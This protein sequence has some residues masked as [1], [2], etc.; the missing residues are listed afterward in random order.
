MDSIG[1]QRP[2]PRTLTGIGKAG[3][4]V[5]MRDTVALSRD[6]TELTIEFSILADA[7]T[8]ASGTAV[9]QRASATKRD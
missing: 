3:G 8:L 4:R 6:D 7:R 5:S 9:F 2:G 1:Y